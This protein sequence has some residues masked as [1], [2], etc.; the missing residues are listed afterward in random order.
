MADI[1]AP[2]LS[3][4]YPLSGAADLNR[5]SPLEFVLTDL[6]GS[7]LKPLSLSVKVNVAG[8]GDVDVFIA[9]VLQNATGWET[10]TYVAYSED[11]DASVGNLKLIKNALFAYADTAVVTISVED[12]LANA[13]LK[14]FN[15]AVVPD[16][17]YDGTSPTPLEASIATSFVD[18]SVEKLR[19]SLIT[20]VVSDA[21]GANREERAARRL[22]QLLSRT[23]QQPLVRWIWSEDP[24][25]NNGPV[26]NGNSLT[27]LKT[28][29][30]DL[31]INARQV[32]N[33]IKYRVESEYIE[34]L[35]TAK[36]LLGGFGNEAAAILTLVLACRMRANGS[37]S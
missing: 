20:A 11:G 26:L 4:L 16:P 24:D 34:Y 21:A 30:A 1:I 6:G 12:N 15:Y 2:Y 22:L 23:S 17:R 27:S 35:D 10:N 28:I 5:A 36:E 33:T 19:T 18:P 3:A 37:I 14:Q 31:V 13:T 32:V 8:G 25:L 7:K 29:E 9:G